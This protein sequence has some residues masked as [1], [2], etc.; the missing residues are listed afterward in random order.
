MPGIDEGI[1]RPDIFPEHPKRKDE[2]SKQIPKQTDSVV[3]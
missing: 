2:Q 3:A 1:P